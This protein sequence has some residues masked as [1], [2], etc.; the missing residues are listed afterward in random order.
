VD[1]GVNP[2]HKV[3]TLPEL[4]LHVRQ[5]RRPRVIHDRGLA[6]DELRECTGAASKFGM[7]CVKLGVDLGLDMHDRRANIC[8]AQ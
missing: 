4:S 7:V 8:G 2:T 3:R 5:T 6:H 1:Q